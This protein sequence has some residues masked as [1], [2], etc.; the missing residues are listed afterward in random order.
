M[1]FHIIIAI[2]SREEHQRNGL[3]G[4]LLSD[5]FLF[6]DQDRLTDV[7]VPGSVIFIIV[8]VYIDGNYRVITL[9]FT[10]YGN[11]PLYLEN[12]A[13]FSLPPIF[14]KGL[15]IYTLSYMIYLRETSGNIISNYHDTHTHIHAYI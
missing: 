11:L 14:T 5:T 15:Y 1:W 12:Y 7:H 8:A 6:L 9:I 4:A 3:G 13:L 10:K 2:G